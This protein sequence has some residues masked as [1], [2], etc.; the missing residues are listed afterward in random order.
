MK[1][2]TI[3]TAI[4]GMLIM[5]DAVAQQ[6]PMYSQYMFNMM[7]INP[8]YTGSREVHNLT[9]LL[10][11]QWSG[12]PGAPTSGSVTYDN[13]VE[14]R[15]HS[16]GAQM[17]YDKI[18]IEKTTGFQGFYS[19][20]APFERATLSLGLN[21]GML[22]YNINYNKTNPY[23]VG[24]PSL[25]SVINKFL[26]TAGLGAL[27]SGDRWYVGLS[28]PAL[29]KTKVS[30][31]GQAVIQQAG[32]EGHY[33]LSAGYVIPVSEAVVIKPSTLLKASSGAPLQADLNMNVWVNDII[34]FGGSYRSSDAVVGMI[35]LKLNP[36]FRLG[37]AYDHNISDLVNYNSGTHEFMLRYELGGKQGKKIV[38]P[39]Y[40]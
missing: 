19:Y 35:E 12:F 37:Y 23:D 26:P 6:T 29:M 15:N 14:G 2:I 28:A 3:I 5:G 10:R 18:G 20:S 34:G 39:R 9:M 11:S 27:L 13:R 17:Y 22:N 31:D 7:N 4:F 33:F 1:K 21:F 8:A 30:S 25:Q 24:D 32:A 40:F 38:S 36:M 16:W